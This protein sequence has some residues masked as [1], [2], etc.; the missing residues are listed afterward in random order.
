V[1]TAALNGIT[2]GAGNTGVGYY[3]M[4]TM[5]NGTNNTAMGSYALY[6]ATGGSNTAMGWGALENNSTATNNT[7]VGTAALRTNTTGAENTA[8]GT[9]A[10]NACTD[11]S[12]HAIF[13]EGAGVA[14]TTGNGNTCIGQDAGA[15]LTS[16]SNNIHVGKLA[17]TSGAG[18]DFEIVLGCTTTGKGTNTGFMDANDGG[19]YA[20]NNSASWSTTSDRRIKKN[21]EDNNTGLDKLKQ[22]QVRNFEYRLPEEVDA[23]LPSHT[24][25]NREGVQVG[26]IAQEIMEILPD[27]VK[28]ESTGCYSVDPD[29]LTW[30]LVNAVKELS[31]KVED[32][33]KQLNNK[34]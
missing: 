20:G 34:E 15:A 14:I 5:Q 23:E 25:I 16:G 10:L 24:A 29:N 18:A 19:N 27:V 3:A 11:G 32:L 2:T 31:T 9:N 13:G 12:Y 30:Y 21:I 33:E 26:V 28:Q 17:A 4:A 22:I 7:A 8:V 1:G 6:L